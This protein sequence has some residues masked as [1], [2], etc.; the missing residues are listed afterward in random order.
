MRKLLLVLAFCL[1]ATSVFAQTSVIS[2]R[3][4]LPEVDKEGNLFIKFSPAGQFLSAPESERYFTVIKK[5]DIT[6]HKVPY[7]IEVVPPGKYWGFCTWDIAEFFWEPSWGEGNC[8]AYEGD[9]TGGTQELI[10]IQEGET[11]ENID[12]ECKNYLGQTEK[13][14][15]QAAYKILDIRYEKNTENNEPKILVRIKNI[16]TKPIGE[17]WMGCFIN[18]EE[19]FDFSVFDLEDLLEP[20]EQ[21]EFDMTYCYTDTYL[22]HRFDEETLRLKDAGPSVYELDIKLV[23]NDNDEVFE[24]HITVT[25]VKPRMIKEVLESGMNYYEIIWE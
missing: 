17:I 1:L 3:V 19:T 23:S 21:R 4:E 22:S 8:P 15:Y 20:G 7:K 9:Y 6:S 2:G 13:S 16:D 24:K 18:G 10:V 25:D 12:F 11:L 5:E 14:G